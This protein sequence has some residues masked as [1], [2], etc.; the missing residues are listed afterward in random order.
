MRTVR[1]ELLRPH[2]ILEE[3]ERF[4]VVY[5][6]IGPLEWHGPHLPLG[7]DPLNAE[8][9]ARLVAEQTG[10][11]VL[12]TFFWGTERERKPE[13]L[14]SIGFKED[15]WV[16]G[17]DFPANSMPSLY[18]AE[19]PFGVAVREYLRLL[20]KQKYKLIVIVNGHGGENH[21]ETLIRLAKE[22]T[23]ETE[24]KVLYTIATRCDNGNVDSGH[25]NKLE[26]SIIMHYFPNCVD[27]KQL[28]PRDV[29]LYNLDYAIVDDASFRGNPAS[30][31]SV[32]SDP[33]DATCELGSSTV[34]S[35]VKIISNMVKKA[36][37]KE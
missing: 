37:C 31:F 18:I 8:A 6:P 22:F 25:A 23:A 2:E 30:D 13:M 26:T 33:R 27:L 34:E 16:V 20:V 11:V 36:L 32:N 15:D 10:G 1:F 21:V 29:K 35:S 4:P 3:K 7:T 9:T 28:P 19:D 24:S 17:M 14:K 12:P 5:L